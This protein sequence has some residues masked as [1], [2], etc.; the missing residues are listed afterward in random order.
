ML[1]KDKG[2]SF[3]NTNP[4]ESDAH[5]MLFEPCGEGLEFLKNRRALKDNI[6]LIKML[7]GKK[8]AVNQLWIF[9]FSFVVWRPRSAS[10]YGD[11]LLDGNQESHK[12]VW[13]FITL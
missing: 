13:N 12:R 3:Y 1:S 4:I 8:S 9:F 5:N 11:F 7:Q 2:L 10:D 6:I